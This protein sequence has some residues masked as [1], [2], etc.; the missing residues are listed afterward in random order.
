MANRTEVIGSIW[1]DGAPDVADGSTPTPNVT[2]GKT[3]AT[4]EEIIA[5][6]P[7]RAVAD[8]SLFNEMMRR[9][10]TLLSLMETY[11]TLPWCAATTYA[12]GAKCMGSD[13]LEY[14][15]LVSN[16]NHNPVSSPTYWIPDEGKG[17]L[18]AVGSWT[19]PGGLILKWGTA[20]ANSGGV[21]YTYAGAGLE[22]FPTACFIV[23]PVTSGV[24]SGLSYGIYP[25]SK[26]GFTIYSSDATPTVVFL[27]IG[28]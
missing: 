20:S 22:D 8:G 16:T 26:T 11:G 6:W 19:F 3:G 17:T 15:A 23:L 1:A 5:A 7:Y 10:T 28:C 27:A 25:I 2:Y 24:A 14:I 13:G 21:P 4:A 12:L 9:V 18:D